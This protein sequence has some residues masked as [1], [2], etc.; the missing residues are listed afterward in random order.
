MSLI[1]V[2]PTLLLKGKGLLKLLIL[3][4]IIWEI[5][6]T[7]SD[8]N[9][10]EVDELVLLDIEASKEKKEP[11]YNWI[12]IVSESFMLWRWNYFNRTNKKKYLI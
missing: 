3:R 8:F 2:I 9:D 4:K 6:L 10:K 11:N 1:R 7:P 5:P 12:Y